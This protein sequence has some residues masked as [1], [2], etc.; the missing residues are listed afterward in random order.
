MTYFQQLISCVDLHAILGSENLV[1]LDASIP[2]V[3]N[4][5]APENSWPEYRIPSA[6]RFDL[7]KDFSDP[8]S[9][10]PHTMP[11][12]E[13]FEQAAK[14]LG[15]NQQSQIVVYDDLGL[16]SAAR[17]WYMFRA[18]GHK[19]IAVLDGG[20]PY[21]LKLKKPID[22][23]SNFIDDTPKVVAGN[24]GAK[25]QVDF[26]C[27]WQDVEAQ[28]RSQV[29]LILD[30]RANRRFT[31][32][33][34]EPRSG[35]RS[36]HM[37]NAKNLPYNDLLTHGRLKSPDELAEIFTD[38]NTDKKAMI[39]TCG[40]GVTACVLALAADIVNIKDVRVYDG[41]WSEWGS[42]THTEVVTST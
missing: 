21:W 33:D 36:G 11:T 38:I 30:A 34:A 15:I 5:A 23:R 39:M 40:S 7:N 14:A 13:H 17:A 24:F 3:G 28:T 9:T 1:I 26:F 27:N 35:V 31:G 8:I 41:S 16:F 18:M 4:M 29:N 20:L 2:P 42:L 19:N 22:E 6:R 12:S 25:A 10:L 37:P 32:A